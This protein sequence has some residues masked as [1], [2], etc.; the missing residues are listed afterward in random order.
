MRLD[1]FKE[2]KRHGTD[3]FPV[4]YY[5]VNSAHEQYVMPLHWHT[6]L[7]VVRIVSG[8]LTLY[9]N[10]SEY[11]MSGGDVAIVS[12]GALHRAEPY[13]CVYECAVFDIS[14]ASGYG[15]RR[16]FDMMRPIISSDTEISVS[17]PYAKDVICELI[18]ALARG[19][20]YYE[21]RVS[22][23]I[24][25][26]VR[27]LY[28]AGAIEPMRADG[29]RGS[30]RRAAIALLIDKI[31]KEYSHRLSLCELAATVG[32]NEKYMCR[33]FKEFT[34]MTP[35]DYANRVRIDRACHNMTVNRMNV[36]EAAFECGFNELS[37]FSKV[38]KKYKGMSPG[39][40]RRRYGLFDA[41]GT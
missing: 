28:L 5:F 16:V 6:E 9:V 39:Q 13:E 33:I 8:R 17:C 10:N 40:Y 29:G 41:S 1:D 14:V 21:L 30:N 32:M 35:L 12:S 31:E 25:E 20:D 38:F 34:G 15:G 7:E 22:S 36:T 2:R 37:Y 11:D 24:T 18:D 4:Q 27:T 23:L 3:D 26:L 19:E